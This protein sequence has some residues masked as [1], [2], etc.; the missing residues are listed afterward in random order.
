MDVDNGGTICDISTP[1]RT[2]EIVAADGKEMT[3]RFRGDSRI[4][5]SSQALV[6]LGSMFPSIRMETGD[7]ALGPVREFVED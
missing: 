6:R 5:Y 4:Q 7:I 2:D 1:G 3:I